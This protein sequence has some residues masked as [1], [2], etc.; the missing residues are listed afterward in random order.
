IAGKRRRQLTYFFDEVGKS[1]RPTAFAVDFFIA[2]GNVLLESGEGQFGRVHGLARWVLNLNQH[3]ARVASPFPDVP[4]AEV[5]L[6]DGVDDDEV[7]QGGADRKGERINCGELEMS[8]GA[9][10]DQDHAEV[11]QE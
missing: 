5:V 1:F 11:D 8:H 6:K 3:V 4:A 9:R 7:V 2:I 10:V